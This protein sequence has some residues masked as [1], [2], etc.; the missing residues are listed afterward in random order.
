MLSPC[1]CFLFGFLVICSLFVPV[2]FNVTCDPLNPMSQELFVFIG[3]GKSHFSLHR[4][5]SSLSWWFSRIPF[6]TTCVLSYDFIK[7]VRFL[8]MSSS[9][10]TFLVTTDRPSTSDLALM[11]SSPAILCHKATNQLHAMTEIEHP[12]AHQFVMSPNHYPSCT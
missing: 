7:L 11:S 9:L 10:P 1:V 2:L 12:C 8:I 6:S 5:Y 3:C 4:L